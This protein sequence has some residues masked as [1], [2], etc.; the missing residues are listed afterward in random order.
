MSSDDG[1]TENN[2][3]ENSGAKNSSRNEDGSLVKRK[4]STK[5]SSSLPDF[6][7]VRQERLVRGRKRHPSP[8]FHPRYA[9][10]YRGRISTRFGDSFVCVDSQLPPADSEEGSEESSEVTRSALTDKGSGYFFRE[11]VCQRISDEIKSAQNTVDSPVSYTHL[12]LPT[13]A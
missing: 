6:Q 1:S 9:N 2:S 8:G 13:K 12:T 3:T 11:P 5:G 7:Q 4:A 10:P